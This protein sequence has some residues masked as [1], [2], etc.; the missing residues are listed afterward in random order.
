MISSYKIPVWARGQ[1]DKMRRNC[2]WKGG[3]EAS[4]ST[5]LVNWEEVCLPKD[6]GGLGVQSLQIMNKALLRKWI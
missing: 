4:S 3:R 2:F 6:Q 5:C 1:I